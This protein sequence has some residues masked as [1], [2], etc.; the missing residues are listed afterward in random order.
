MTNDIKIIIQTITPVSFVTGQNDIPCCSGNDGF[1]TIHASDGT[2]P[3]SYS[4]DG[5]STWI[6]SG[7][8]PYP[9]GNLIANHTYKIMV[10][11]NLGCMSPA[12][13]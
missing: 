12:I 6:S 13:P 3:Y 5:G 2:C 7:T 9:Y 11:D 1:I 8:D 4:V 10:R